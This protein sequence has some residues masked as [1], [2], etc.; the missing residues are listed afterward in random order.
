[1]NDVPEWLFVEGANDVWLSLAAVG[2]L[3]GLLRGRRAALGLVAYVSVAILV[4]SSAR[5]GLPASWVLPPFALAIS[6]F[7]PVALGLALLGEILYDLAVGQ[8]A[9][10]AIASRVLLVAI[11][12]VTVHG[13]WRTRSIVNPVTIIVEPAD[14]VA[15]D[16]VREHTPPEA[17]F[18]VSAGHWHLNTYRGLDGGYWLPILAARPTTMPAAF[19]NYGGVEY[20]RAVLALA[21]T[22]A[23]GDALTD[24]EL[25]ALMAQTGADYVYVGPHSSGVGGTLTAERLQQSRLLEQIYEGDGAYVFRRAERP[26]RVT[27]GAESVVCQP[28]ARAEDPARSPASD[29]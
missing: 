15:A 2:I 20:A 3:F 28:V 12:V 27:R 26:G 22:V 1:V 10:P 4:V 16:W 17:C 9:D 14:I 24:D 19:Y 11:L 29:R 23:R 7:I 8:R 6:A 21:E 5:L 13:A 18:L 25:E